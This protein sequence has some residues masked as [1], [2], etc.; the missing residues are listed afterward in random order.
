MATFV[1]RGMPFFVVAFIL[2]RWIYLRGKLMRIRVPSNLGE[3][4]SNFSV[5]GL[6]G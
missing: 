1:K 6:S 4:C 3:E 2:V 5:S